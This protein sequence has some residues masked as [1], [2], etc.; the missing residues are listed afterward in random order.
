MYQNLYESEQLYSQVT[1]ERAVMMSPVE[2]GYNAVGMPKTVTS[3]AEV[4]VM[5]PS[6]FEEMPQVIQSLREHKSVLLNLKRM[7]PE[8]AQRAVDFVVGGIYAIEGHQER[9]GEKLFL[10][11]PICVQVTI[12]QAGVVRQVAPPQVLQSLQS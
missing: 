3:M 8:Q 7:E 5:E 12:I 4:V 2:T 6:S 9:V 1:Q 10:F 11:T